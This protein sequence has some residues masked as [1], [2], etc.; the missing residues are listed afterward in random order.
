MVGLVIF[1]PFHDVHEERLISNTI[2]G[3]SD[4]LIILTN[5]TFCQDN[6]DGHMRRGPLH[7]QAQRQGQEG[8]VVHQEPGRNILCPPLIL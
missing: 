6:Q 1:I 5:P 8:Q 7:L 2:M 3:P 4:N